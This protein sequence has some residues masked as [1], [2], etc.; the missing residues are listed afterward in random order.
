MCLAILGRY[1]PPVLLTQ[2]L[3][4]LDV[5][6]TYGRKAERQY[7]LW[8][9][10]RC[11]LTEADAAG[12][13]GLALALRAISRCAS[14]KS[15]EL[16]DIELGSSRLAVVLPQASRASLQSLHLDVGI[17]DDWPRSSLADLAGFTSLTHLHIHVDS[18][19][20][21]G[22][23]L[24][25]LSQL[26]HLELSDC[27]ATQLPDDVV[28]LPRLAV[29]NLP[30]CKIRSLPPE[31]G[32]LTALQVLNLSEADALRALPDLTPLTALHTLILN[33]PS[34]GWASPAQRHLSVRM[35]RL[36]LAC[37][38]VH[39]PDLSVCYTCLSFC[40]PIQESGL[41]VCPSMRMP[42]HP[43]IGQSPLGGLS[44]CLSSMRWPKPARRPA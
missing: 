40:L 15:L 20:S 39:K 27:R 22:D 36:R 18:T 29:L 30:G 4:L 41:S 5:R 23:G 9:L 19:I 43:P 37:L 24:S 44:V 21:L 35:C 33:G 34:A 38:P 10:W 8:I 16:H 31:F 14:L 28:E 11:G 13:R 42:A 26:T 1:M 12:P 32:R 7:A 6:F 2:E 17:Q 3:P 25:R